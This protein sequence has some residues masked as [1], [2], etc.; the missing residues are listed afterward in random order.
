MTSCP[1]VEELT[2]LLADA[3]DPADQDALAQH[4]EGCATCQEQLARLT[5]TP[6]T[7]TRRRAGPSPRASGAEDSV[8]LRLKQMASL[9]A[10]TIL[11]QA[12]GPPG[13]AIRR[14]AAAASEWPA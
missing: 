13:A 2:S 8:M 10:P 4:V 7:G 3:L 5:G 11:M 9:P 12:P 1:T 6:D 14:P